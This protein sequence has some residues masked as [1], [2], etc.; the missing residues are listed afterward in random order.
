MMTMS[1]TASTAIFQ[2]LNIS[3]ELNCNLLIDTGSGQY[4]QTLPPAFTSELQA[5][6]SYR[7]DVSGGAKYHP[8]WPL[9]DAVGIKSSGS[10]LVWGL[11]SDII[12]GRV[13]RGNWIGLNDTRNAFWGSKI[14]GTADS[15][16]YEF[17]NGIA[18]RVDFYF[19]DDEC[20]DNSGSYALHIY[21]IYFGDCVIMNA[22]LPGLFN[23]TRSECCAQ[24]GITCVGS[25]ITEMYEHT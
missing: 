6:V 24:A 15:Y 9:V 10:G 4:A 2:S 1:V 13:L 16:S 14:E 22:W 25:R 18:Q 17:S 7:F 20:S 23:A 3:A 12:S 21:E 19:S 11:S 5:G 8:A